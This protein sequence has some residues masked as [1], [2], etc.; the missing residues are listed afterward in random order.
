MRTAACTVRNHGRL[1]RRVVAIRQA[2]TRPSAKENELTVPRSPRLVTMLAVSTG[3]AF[4][5]LVGAQGSFAKT[6]AC[7][8]EKSPKYPHGGAGGYF[9][10]LEVTNVSCKT[11][12]KFIVAYYK[13][14]VKNG[15]GRG[16]CN[17]KTVSGFKCGRESRPSASQ[18]PEQLNAKVTCKRANKKI[19]HTYQHNFR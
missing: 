1:A 10:S 2:G 12:K 5:G 18:S 11:G 4:A 8:V 3:L 19:V 16:T 13:C 14:R 17:G 15:G 6:T 7:N 9:T